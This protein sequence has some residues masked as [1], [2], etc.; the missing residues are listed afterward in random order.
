MTFSSQLGDQLDWTFA[1]GQTP[2]ESGHGPEHGQGWG[3]AL[4]SE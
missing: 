1:A 3:E 2:E 4:M